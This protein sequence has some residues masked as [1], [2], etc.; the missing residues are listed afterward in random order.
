MDTTTERSS[1]HS[2]ART[3]VLLGW[4]AKAVVYLALAW[5][6]LQLAFGSAPQQT[7]ATGALQYIAQTGP[8]AVAIVLVGVGLLAHAVG[9]ILEVT[10]LARPGIGGKDKLEAGFLALVY[11]SLAVSAL[12]IVGLAGGRSSS[13]GGSA[14]QQGSAFLLGLPGGRWLVGIVGLA[15]AGFGL[16][17]AYQGLQ[18][19]FLGTLRTSEMSHGVREA[20]KKLGTAAYVTR[21]AIFVLL[22]WF[23]VQSALTYDPSQARGLDGALQ[24]VA[25]Q[26]WGKVV[27]ALV[28]LGLFAYAAFNAFEARYRKVGV[29]ATGTR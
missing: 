25:Q 8:G 6:V 12:S 13:G 29:S 5:L 20:V 24:E 10:L 15:V 18:Q 22:A 1:G 17:Q 9:R 7:S 27:L 14:E 19:A 3:L 21:G 2:A 16:H 4:G 11:T 28:A 23:L 26:S